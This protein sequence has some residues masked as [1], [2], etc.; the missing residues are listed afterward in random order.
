MTEEKKNW[1]PDRKDWP[2]FDKTWPSEEGKSYRILNEALALLLLEDYVITVRGASVDCEDSTLVVDAPST[3]SLSVM[4][5][6]TFAYASA[7]S[8]NLPLLGWQD[9][10]EEQFW[11][12]YD[13][14]RELG[15]DG[16]VQWIA[17]RRGYRPIPPVVKKMKEAGTWLPEMDELEP[18]GWEKNNG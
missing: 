5:S 15:Y 18:N 8:E 2:I 9:E 13:K 12:L 10:R 16:A 14:I 7:D 6:D 1:W 4:C 17:L 11:N 3:V